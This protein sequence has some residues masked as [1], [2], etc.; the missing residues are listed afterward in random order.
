[1]VGERVFKGEYL[2]HL[3]APPKEKSKNHCVIPKIFLVS[4]STLTS[5][6]KGRILIDYST[7]P[8]DTHASLP[9]RIGVGRSKH[10]VEPSTIRK[11][12]TLL[13]LLVHIRKIQGG[14]SLEVSHYESKKWLVCFHVL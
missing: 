6:S 5:T 14:I 12:K 11:L 3:V 13:L 4:S 10:L 7:H 8:T 2:W 9:K 1:M